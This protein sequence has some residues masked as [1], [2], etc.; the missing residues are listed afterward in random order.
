MAAITYRYAQAFQTSHTVAS[1]PLL[2]SRANLSGS[3]RTYREP[4]D[5]LFWMVNIGLEHVPIQ[6]SGFAVIDAAHNMAKWQ[7]SAPKQSTTLDLPNIWFASLKVASANLPPTPTHS[8]T[9]SG[10]PQT[11]QYIP[12]ANTKTTS[13]TVG[14]GRV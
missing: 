1:R 2:V 13:S 7:S 12:Y 9:H 8:L 4:K 6:A 3:N 10:L 14:D 5:S 11:H